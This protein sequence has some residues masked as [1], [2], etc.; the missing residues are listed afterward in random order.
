MTGITSTQLADGREL[1]YFD[2]AGPLAASRTAAATT[3]HRELPERGAPGEIRFD[4]LT[5]EWVAVAAHRQTR[6]HLPPADQCPICPTTAHNPS[7]IPAPD[8]DVVVFENR[9]PSLGPAVGH[10]PAAPAWGTTGPAYGRCE[11]VSFTPEHTGSFSGLSEARARTVMEAW[12]HRTEALS[13]SP[14][15]GRC[16]LRKPRS[17]H[18]RHPAPPAWPD[19][20][21]PLCHPKGRDPRRCGAKIL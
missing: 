21:V 18:R 9:F 3:D 13:K 10:V 7:E 14:A 5:D 12:A 6:T 20:R 8:Y 15:S 1:I 11:V 16:S 19:L 17:R 2:D 4:A